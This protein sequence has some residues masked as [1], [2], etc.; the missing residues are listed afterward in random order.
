MSNDLFQNLPTPER[1]TVPEGKSVAYVSRIV[2]LGTQTEDFEGEEKTKRQIAI[3]LEFPEHTLEFEEGKGPQPL[4][5]SR[6]YTAS[7]HKKANLYP[8]LAACGVELQAIDG[9][10][11]KALEVHII[12]SE[13]KAG[14]LFE[15]IV[16]MSAALAPDT[17]ISQKPFSYFI[18]TH[19]FE[20]EV[21]DALA[22]WQKDL[23]KASA[24]YD[25]LPF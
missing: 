9:A 2:D 10:L 16:K 5:I 15:K 1:Q 6:R 4:W 17:P 7:A 18:E 11:G 23:L 14:N 13:T 3:T 8:F 25:K 24:E 12:H 20:G 19:A 22:D 21:W